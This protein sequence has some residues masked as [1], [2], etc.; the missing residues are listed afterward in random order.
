MCIE[1]I[2]LLIWLHFFADFVLQSDKMARNKSSSNK[3]LAIHVAVYSLP[4][5]LIGF[6]YAILNGIL[7]FI[8]DYA[9]S[10]VSSKFYQKGDIHSFFVI[11][12]FDQAIHITTLVLTYSLMFI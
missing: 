9:S 12:G 2:L 11:V 7:H 1:I 5:L 8:T 10:R 3:W 4:F 6:H